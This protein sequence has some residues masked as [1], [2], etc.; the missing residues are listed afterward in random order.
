MH[1]LITADTVG[2]VWTYTRELVTG[3]VRRG[4][5]VTLVSFGRIPTAAQMT[6]LEGLPGVEYF[7]TAFRLEWMT[8]ADRDLDDAM[9]YLRAII[10][11]CKPEDAH[12]GMRVEAV[13]P[14]PANSHDGRMPGEAVQP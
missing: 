6:W 2:G 7:P 14:V 4:V 10:Q 5:R 12:M 13:T 9:G 3:L 8:D 11:E 1:V